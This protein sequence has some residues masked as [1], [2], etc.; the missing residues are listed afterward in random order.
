MR[1][2]VPSECSQFF[3]CSSVELP[4]FARGARMRVTS[5]CTFLEFSFKAS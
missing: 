3:F 2:F 5:L 4:V 1:G